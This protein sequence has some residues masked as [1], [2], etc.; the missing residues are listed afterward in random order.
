MHKRCLSRRKKQKSSFS[1]QK[2]LFEKLAQK[3]HVN[4][5]NDHNINKRS[6]KND[7]EE[8]GGFTHPHLELV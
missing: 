8:T 3:L 1:P 5:V 4:K 2:K 7:L 6:Q